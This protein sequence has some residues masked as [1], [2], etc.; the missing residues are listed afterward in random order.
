MINQ[1][2]CSEPYFHVAVVRY[3]A[4]IILQ[5]IKLRGGKYR[6]LE[7]ILK[8]FSCHFSSLMIPP[9]LLMTLEGAVPLGIARGTVVH[10]P[11]TGEVLPVL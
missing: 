3:Y 5:P 4:N 10:E 11:V 8:C 2:T 7:I 6:L 1:Y 9:V